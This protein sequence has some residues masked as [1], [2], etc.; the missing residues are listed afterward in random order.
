M[1]V[2]IEKGVNV[3]SDIFQEEHN[4]EYISFS[5][6]FISGELL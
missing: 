3:P 1:S 5:T 2:C 6:W 4:G